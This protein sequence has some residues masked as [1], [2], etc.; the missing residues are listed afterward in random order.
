MSGKF[1]MQWVNTLTD[2]I[3]HKGATV[4]RTASGVII[5]VSKDVNIFTGCSAI[6]TGGSPALR[7]Y[8]ERSFLR[9]PDE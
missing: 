8:L 5:L 9:R 1:A 2:V 4:G 6:S 3:A 7:A